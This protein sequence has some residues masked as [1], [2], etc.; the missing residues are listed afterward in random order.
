MIIKLS[1]SSRARL[2]DISK[3]TGMTEHALIRRAVHDFI[4]TS[5]IEYRL[6]KFAL[7]S[8]YGMQVGYSDTDSVVYG[9]DDDGEK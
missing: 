6:G 9:G 1:R 7:S 4:L 5:N 8:L 3:K 2:R